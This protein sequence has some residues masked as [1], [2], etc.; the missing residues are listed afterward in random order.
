MRNSTLSS[1]DSVAEWS[2]I[3]DSVAEWSAVLDSVAEW[4]AVLDLVTEW[5]AVLDSVFH[6]EAA[7]TVFPSEPVY[8][9]HVFHTKNFKYNSGT[10]TIYFD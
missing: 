2:A 5:S 8:C 3:L 7:V 10:S 1:T 4:S 6:P 9:L